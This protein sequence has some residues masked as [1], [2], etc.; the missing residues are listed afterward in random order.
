MPD[1]GVR[2]YCGLASETTWNHHPVAPGQYACISPVTGKTEQT[3]KENRIYVPSESSVIQDSGAF[4]DSLKNR[5]NFQQAFDR[6]IAHAEKYH[7]TNQISHSA[8]YDILIDEVW[9][10]G[11][12]DKRRWTVQDAEFAVDQTVC[13]AEFMANHKIRPAILSAQ[14]VDAKQY[15]SCVS[16]ILFYLDPEDILGLGGWCITGKMRKVMTPVF[17]ETIL[18][19]IPYVAKHNV[20]W[21][22]I[23]GVIYPT[24]LG[25]LL[26]LCDQYDIKVSTDSAGPSFRP[27]MGSW[28]YDGWTDNTYKRPPVEIRGL[29]R[30][31]HVQQTRS[32]LESLRETP[33]YQRP[34]LENV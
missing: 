8:S 7:Y 11:N 25:E 20:K 28:G 30:A 15:K 21:V 9:T 27:A 1:T 33:Y 23:W 29:E 26:W 4:C 16:Q 19:V 6:Q 10:N 31:R 13:S 18:T 2:F 5:L 24:A 34:I 12:R 3:R 32:W 14:G 22:H 17:R